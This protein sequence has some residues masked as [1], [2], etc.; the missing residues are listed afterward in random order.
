MRLAAA[1]EVKRMFY[2][3]YDNYLRHA[4]PHDELKPLSKKYTDSLGELGN[5]RRELLSSSYSGVALT[6]IDA[7]S[8]LA[9]LDNRTEFAKNVKWMSEH[10]DFDVDVRVNAFECNI[11]VLGGLLSAHAI[12]AGL[13]PERDAFSFPEENPGGSGAGSAAGSAADSGAGRS[14]YVP[15]YGNEVLPLAHDLG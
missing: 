6:L 8:T 10:L 4:F 1:S 3:G 12:A 7:T 15:G 11:R 13:I 14:P 2:H 5:L 9:I